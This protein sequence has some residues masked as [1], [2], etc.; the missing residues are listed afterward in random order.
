METP[1]IDFLR[2]FSDSGTSRFF[3]PGHKGR[4][5]LSASFDITEIEGA[6]FLLASE[7]I[8]ARSE[9]LT[10]SLYGA[11]HTLYSTQ[12]STLAILAM[13][14]AAVPRG[15]TLIA[16]RNCHAACVNGMALLDL[17]P[18]FVAQEG[19][20]EG[21]AGRTTPQGVRRALQE[22]PEASAVYITS[23]DYFGILSDVAG[24]AAVCREYGVPLLC[25]NAHGAHLCLKERGADRLPEHPIRL[26]AAMTADSAHKTLPALTGGA[27]LHLA[28]E[29]YL[30]KAR[31]FRRLFASTS[32]SYLTVASLDGCIPF[33]EEGGGEYAALI[34][35]NDRIRSLAREKGFFF[36]DGPLSDPSRIALY[37][38]SAGYEGEELGEIVRA[39]GIE[40]E[41]VT[42]D[43]LVFLPSPANCREDFRRLSEVFQ[44]LEKRP[45]KAVSPPPPLPIPNR[46]MRV[47]D[48]VFSC[49]ERIPV[50]QAEGRIAASVN[51]PCPPCV[52]LTVPGE[53][54]DK[55]ICELLQYYGISHVDVV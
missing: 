48:A 16:G 42:P 17:T 13:I 47:Q 27:Y 46:G 52:P 38:P 9:S 34:E 11:A 33:L 41:M 35:E 36:P 43:H 40:P 29:C 28:E 37:C 15:G 49:S 50:N 18:V 1:V 3:M 54:L 31:Q 6:D 45:A 39:K 10:A 55:N 51:C 25:D 26:G 24:I 44:S 2:R 53:V 12:G 7:G 23:P 21:F 4:L 19:G 30:P 22:H 8:I 14:A 20:E 32:P 5:E